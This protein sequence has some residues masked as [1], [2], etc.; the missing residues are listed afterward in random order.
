MGM[1]NLFGETE[2]EIMLLFL[3]PVNLF[4]VIVNVKFMVCVHGL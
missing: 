4:K 1:K 2:Y 3:K